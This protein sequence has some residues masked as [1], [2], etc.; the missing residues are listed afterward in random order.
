MFRRRLITDKGRP[1]P[2]GATP[3]KEGVNFSIYSKHATS[4]VL[5]LFNGF[6]KEVVLLNFHPVTS[7]SS[8]L[9]C[10]YPSLSHALA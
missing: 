1:Y 7:I 10:L 8:I 5:C 4:I 2:L 9:A 3:D 6:N